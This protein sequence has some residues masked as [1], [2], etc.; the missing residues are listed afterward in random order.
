M[1][2]LSIVFLAVLML[3]SGVKAAVPILWDDLKDPKAARFEDPFAA[4]SGPQLRSL[5]TV[6]QLRQQLN[7]ADGGGNA[8]PAIEQ[9]LRQEEAK[10][11]AA[12]VATDTLLAQ[13]L[14]IGK[15]RAAAALAGN[16]ELVGKEIAITGY[17][18]PVQEPGSDQ[19]DTGYLVPE[20]G[21]CSHVPAPDPN[22][23]I[24]YRLQTDWRPDQIYEPVLL[25]GRLSLKTTRQEITL[26]DGQVDMIAAFELEVTDARSLDE[27]EAPNPMNRI[28]K[29]FKGPVPENSWKHQ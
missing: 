29:F 24:R 6:L 12:G 1:K 26:L 5:G 14:E 23:M 18:I 27:E 20:Q 4:L 9:R 15:K 2:R 19:V 11:A 28:W 7:A 10:L 21:M 22:Q 13:R 25:T 17:V 8:R 16:P 3:A